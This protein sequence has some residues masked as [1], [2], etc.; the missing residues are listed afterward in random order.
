MLIER[1]VNL[2]IEIM[3]EGLAHRTDT[4]EVLYLWRGIQKVTVG[5]QGAMILMTNRSCHI[6]PKRCFVSDLEMWEFGKE[7]ETRMKAANEKKV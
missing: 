7:I 5:R 2:E 3:D 6:V 1:R 4:M